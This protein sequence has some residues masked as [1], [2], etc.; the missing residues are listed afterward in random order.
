LLLLLLCAVQFLDVVDSSIMNI[1]LPSIRPVTAGIVVAAGNSSRLFARIGT[2]P[3]IVGGAL[4]AAAGLWYLVLGH[5]RGVPSR[6]T[7]TLQAGSG[8]PANLYP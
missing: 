3:V 1:A 5:R 8:T 4:I 2:R 6:R 7:R